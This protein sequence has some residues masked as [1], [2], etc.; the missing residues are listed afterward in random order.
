MSSCPFVVTSLANLKHGAVL[1]GDHGLSDDVKPD[2]Y[3]DAKFKRGQ[4]F[5]RRHV[6]AI[7]LS[8][9]CSLVSGLS[10]TTTMIR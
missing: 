2:W 4:A 7:G 10:I 9:H 6:A 3:D 1:E 5:F 8:R